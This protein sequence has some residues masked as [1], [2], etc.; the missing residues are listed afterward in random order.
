M[1]VHTLAQSCLVGGGFPPLV[2]VLPPPKS[3]LKTQLLQSSSDRILLA[4][5]L[6]MALNAMRKQAGVR[7]RASGAKALAP[8]V[9]GRTPVRPVV[10]CAQPSSTASK[11]D[12]PATSTPVTPPVVS[13]QARFG[14]QL[15]SSRKGRWGFL[16]ATFP[17]LNQP[18]PPGLQFPCIMDAHPDASCFQALSITSKVFLRRLSPVPFCQPERTHRC[19]VG[20]H[21]SIIL[22][23]I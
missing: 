17:N 21:E 8:S 9:N 22:H 4:V 10:C 1:P 18:I 14:P 20:A 19:L 15:S 16:F 23:Y 2:P 5:I 11:P 3:V 13:L 7:S 12:T 6:Q